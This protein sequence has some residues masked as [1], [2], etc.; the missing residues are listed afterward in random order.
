ME[1]LPA[2]Y[3]LIR[4]NPPP[5]KL[6]ARKST[7]ENYR[8]HYS[9]S[10]DANISRPLRC[11]IIYL[12]EG[13]ISEL[14]QGQ[15]ITWPQSSVRTHVF[16]RSCDHYSH[17]P[18]TT[19]CFLEFILSEPPVPLTAEEVSRWKNITHFAI[20]PEHIT[21]RDSCTRI[22]TLIQTAFKLVQL[23]MD[24]SGAMARSMR[25]RAIMY[26]CLAILTE[27][28]VLQAQRQQR[29]TELS[30][31]PYTEKARDFIQAHLQDLPSVE[32]IAKH[33]GVSYGHLTRVFRNDLHMSLLEYANRSRVQ[34]AARYINEEGLT[35][36]EAGSRVGISDE[37]DLSRLFRRYMGVSAAEFRQS[38]KEQ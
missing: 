17:D 11:E 1:Q 25:L 32:I 2:P 24:D 6:F 37:K 22:G 15:E 27:Q 38:H 12:K 14:R 13:S 7:K 16:N 9:D 5:R 29:R 31:H 21:H 30:A 20:I 34:V 36:R 28:A 19:E 33:V 3:Y 18:V 23:T 26:E 10:C 4:L 8:W 35:M